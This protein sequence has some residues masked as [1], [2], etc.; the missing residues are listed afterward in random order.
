M[1]IE[2]LPP[3]VQ[4]STPEFGVI[5]GKIRFGLTAIKGCGRSAA[6]AIVAVREKRWSVP[7]YI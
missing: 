1:N 2:V 5:D 3:S 6:E 4:T 7:R